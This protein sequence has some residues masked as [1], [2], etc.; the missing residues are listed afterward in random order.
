[1]ESF[2][3]TQDYILKYSLTKNSLTE[4]EGAQGVTATGSGSKG[5]S[6]PRTRKTWVGRPQKPDTRAGSVSTQPGLILQ[7]SCHLSLMAWQAP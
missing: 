6:E 7:T 4:E 5:A 3:I 1:M 2:S